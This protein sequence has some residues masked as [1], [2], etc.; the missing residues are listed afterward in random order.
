VVDRMPETS[1]ATPDGFVVWLEGIPCSGK[2]TAARSVAERLRSNV[3]LAA[4]IRRILDER[5]G[6]RAPLVRFEPELEDS[7]T[8]GAAQE[9]LRTVI[10][11]GRYAELFSYDDETETFSLEN[12]SS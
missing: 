9:T 6:H 2:T 8:E 1:S 7:L 10:S 12:P 4:H 5:P 11:W 3:P